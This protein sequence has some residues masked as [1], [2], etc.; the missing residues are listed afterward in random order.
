MVTVAICLRSPDWYHVCHTVL[1][2]YV[3]FTL[4]FVLIK[5][6]KYFK[7]IY[8]KFMVGGSILF[9]LRT[10]LNLDPVKGHSFGIKAIFGYVLNC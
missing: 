6:S 3:V 5:Y 8:I 9:F 7:H 2:I 10:S 1:Q 4:G